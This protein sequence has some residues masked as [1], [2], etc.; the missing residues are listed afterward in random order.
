VRYAT[1]SAFRM[2][3]ERRLLDRSRKTGA[4]LSR[5]RKDVTF[6]RLLARLLAAA[7]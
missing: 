1:A 6:D 4:S 2:A 5:L 7:P 3:L